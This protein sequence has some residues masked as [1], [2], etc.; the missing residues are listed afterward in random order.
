MTS[1]E[2]SDAIHAKLLPTINTT[3]QLLRSITLHNS[4]ILLLAPSVTPALRLPSHSIQTVLSSAL[5]SFLSSLSAEL[6]P[7]SASVSHFKLGDIDIPSVT[8]RQRREGI[9]SP[10]RFK[11]TPI[12]QLHNAVFDAL[13]APRPSSVYH[14]GRGS[15][16]Y[17]VIGEWVPPVWIAWMMGAKTSAAQERRRSN[18][19]DDDVL[20]T[21]QRS[22]VMGSLTWEKIDDDG[23]HGSEEGR[24]TFDAAA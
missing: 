4:K 5:T 15:L 18:P 21:S 16:T 2:W 17:D 22:D 24:P 23:D 8:A 11:P 13:V 7:S 10:S 3:T 14:V 6:A 1:E 20:R 9:A 19:D 12:R